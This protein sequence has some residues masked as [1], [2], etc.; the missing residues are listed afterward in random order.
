MSLALAATWHPRGELARLVRLVGPFK[1]VYSGIHIVF[2]PGIESSEEG[3]FLRGAGAQV[4]TSSEWSHGRNLALRGALQFPVDHI[5]YA[6]LDRLMH[7]AETRPEEWQAMSRAIEKG[8][9]LIMGRTPQAYATHPRAL[10][11]TE[12]ISNAVFAHFFGRWMDL[13][14]GSKGFSRRALEFLLQHSESG[15]AL[16]MD[17]AWPILLQRGGFRI[18]YIETDGLDWES[19]DRYKDAVASPEAQR[20]A[21]EEYD[22][23]PVH[24]EHRAQVALEIVEAGLDAMVTP[25]FAAE[26]AVRRLS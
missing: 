12:K 15:R 21:A 26:T 11:Q 16:G 7:W 4:T 18:D 22:R 24:W 13:S 2:P 8:D 17:S 23:D 14:A 10:V 6:D 9:C 5:H 1:E 20:K 25:L 3:R 19:A